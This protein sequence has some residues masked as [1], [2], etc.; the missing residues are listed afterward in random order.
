MNSKLDLADQRDMK[1]INDI[2]MAILELELLGYVFTLD[3]DRIHYKFTGIKLIPELA[4]PWLRIIKKFRMYA[5]E[6]L[7]NRS[8]PFDILPYLQEAAEKAMTSARRAEA[9]GDLDLA[10]RDWR[11]YARIQNAIEPE[12]ETDGS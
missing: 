2:A 12:D 4:L 5:L 3:G 7:R 1:V 8:E 9:K 11:R 6:L 10:Q